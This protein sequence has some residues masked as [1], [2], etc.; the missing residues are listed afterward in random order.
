MGKK[1]NTTE[2][3]AANKV[4][5]KE[6]NLDSNKNIAANKK[7]ELIAQKK[8]NK[9][10]AVK[11]SAWK[12]RHY[13]DIFET[14]K[15]LT[16]R[17][18]KEEKAIKSGFVKAG[19]LIL[20]VVGLPF[21]VYKLFKLFKHKK[22]I[23]NPY[24]LRKII[25]IEEAAKKHKEKNA[26]IIEAYK[27]EKKRIKKLK[28]LPFKILNHLNFLIS[29]FLIIL[30]FFILDIGIAPTALVLFSS[31]T[32]CYFL[33]GLLMHLVFYM[34]SENKTREQML[35]LEEEKNRLLAEEKIKSEELLRNKIE[36]ERRIYE[37]KE[38][39][40]FEEDRLRKEETARRLREAEERKIK[41]EEEARLL[42][43][44]EEELKKLVEEKERLV[45]EKR[46]RLIK[47][48][49]PPA[50]TKAEL[51]QEKEILRNDFDRNLLNELN[52]EFVIPN[53][54]G[55]EGFGDANKLRDEYSGGIMFGNLDSN[56]EAVSSELNNMMLKTEKINAKINDD[57]TDFDTADIE[58]AKTEIFK[59]A[60]KKV[61]KAHEEEL[62]KKEEKEIK[63]K[64]V[65]G[66]SFMLIKEMLKN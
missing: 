16:I 36:K 35:K 53:V 64:A 63:G 43:E 44:A 9:E 39:L 19:L 32:F 37:A 13:A 34:I 15:D 1:N 45:Q 65:S 28:K 7:A 41:E 40:R 8:K 2:I 29:M 61:D 31:F 47:S 54:S 58:E 26:R 27:E 30:F 52:R 57:I 4:E 14:D 25:V 5:P 11:V 17:Q 60:R 42:A 62:Q 18:R 48:E 49:A 38:T 12:L 51:A 21:G 20:S 23:N 59:R 55:I 66:K 24:E 50:L 22:A 6:N 56:E 3:I 46:M 10:R 33:I